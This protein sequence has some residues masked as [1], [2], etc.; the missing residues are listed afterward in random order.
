MSRTSEYLK[1]LSNMFRPGSFVIAVAGSA[2]FAVGVYGKDNGLAITPQ[3][4]CK[5]L[6]FVMLLFCF[7]HHY[8]N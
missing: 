3:M 5:W 8:G 1:T 7:G 6:P 4:G 2:L